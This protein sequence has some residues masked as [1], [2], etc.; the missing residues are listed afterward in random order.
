MLA[1]AAAVAAAAALEQ[2]LA[3]KTREVAQIR[4]GDEDDIAAAAAVTAIRAAFRDIFFPA[5]AQR[6]VAAAARLH[7]N[8][9]AVVEH[10]PY[11]VTDE[12]SLAMPFKRSRGFAGRPL[13]PIA[14]ITGVRK[15][16]EDRN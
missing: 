1:G 3:A 13:T 12:A 8:A 6:A 5:E 15:V 14:G 7:V 4:V 9:G 11:S 10:R 2:A 16:A